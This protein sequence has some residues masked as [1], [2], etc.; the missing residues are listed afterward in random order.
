MYNASVYGGSAFSQLLELSKE[1]GFI[2]AQFP[3]FMDFLD[4]VRYGKVD[5]FTSLIDIIKTTGLIDTYF[6]EIKTQ[7]LEI[8]KIIDSFPE[9]PITHH[10]PFAITSL[11]RTIKG[12]ILEDLPEFKKWLTRNN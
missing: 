4:V 12:S 8:M 7:L 9:E 2:E 10:K 5:R 1:Q 11:T 3:I 6:T